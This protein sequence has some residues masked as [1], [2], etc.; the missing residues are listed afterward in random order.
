MTEEQ[1]AAVVIRLVGG[2]ANGLV[3]AVRANAIPRFLGVGYPV[4]RYE[5]EPGNGD[6][7]I[8]RYVA[9]N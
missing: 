7:R 3:F 4:S 5:P 6:V 2:P 1:Y 9:V 8:Y